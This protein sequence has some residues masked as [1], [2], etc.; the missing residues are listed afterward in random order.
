MIRA[1]RSRSMDGWMDGWMDGEDL[2][3]C[4]AIWTLHKLWLPLI[5]D[6]SLAVCIALRN[7]LSSASL[8]G[9]I[10]KDFGAILGGPNGRHTW[11]LGGSLAMLFSTAFWHRFNMDFSRLQ[12][13]KIIVF[14]EENQ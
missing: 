9:A 12:T 7:R 5:C 14:L 11:Y 10:S 3:I 1:T 2:I 13:L 6:G 4:V 8:F